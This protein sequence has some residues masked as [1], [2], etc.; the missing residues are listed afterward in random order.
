MASPF[1]LLRKSVCLESTHKVD[2][3]LQ[4]LCARLPL[5]GAN[6]AVIFPHELARLKLTQKLLGITANITGVDF[7]RNNLAIGVDDERAAL[8]Y[9]LVLNEH[10]EIARKC[11]GR[12]G[13]HG[14]GELLDALRVVMPCLVCEVRIAGDGVDFT[15]CILEVLVLVLQILKLG[16]AHEGEICGVEEENAPLTAQVLLGDGDKFVVLECLN[17]EICNFLI[18]E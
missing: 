6:L 8:S 1:K 2:A 7:V 12:V 3:R 18:N 13:E 10:L 16:G 14:V 15:A 9:T 4:S 11:V 5:S 17:A